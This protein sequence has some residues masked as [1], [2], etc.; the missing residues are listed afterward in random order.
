MGISLHPD[1]PNLHQSAATDGDKMLAMCDLNGNGVIDI[2]EVFGDE[3]LHPVT[4]Q[5]LNAS[6]GFEALRLVAEEVQAL[7]PNQHITHRNATGSLIVYLKELQKGLQELGCSLGFIHDENI[8]TL[9]P[10]DG[11]VAVDVS[12]YRE[13]PDDVRDGIMYKEKSSFVDE[14]NNTWE[15]DDVWFQDHN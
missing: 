10:L 3:T 7:C 13:T 6:N 4:K 9:E 11:A 8:R 15:V 5:A 14:R 2:Q 1:Q 12:G